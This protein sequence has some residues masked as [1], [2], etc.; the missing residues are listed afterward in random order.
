MSQQPFFERGMNGLVILINVLCKK[1]H[2]RTW[3]EDSNFLML[4]IFFFCEPCQLGKLRREP[5]NSR[6]RETR[7][8][9]S[10]FIHSNICGPMSVE[11]FG[12]RFFVTFID[13]ASNFRYVYFLKHKS[14]L[15]D[16]F[17]EFKRLLFNKFG[18]SM[19]T[20]HMDNKREYC[21]KEM[22]RYITSRGITLEYTAPYT[23]EQ[24]GKSKRENRTIVESAQTMLY[25]KKPLSLWAEAVN[26]T[27]CT[28]NRT[29]CVRTPGTTPFQIWTGKSRS[30]RTWEYLVLKHLCTCLTLSG[31]NWI[32]N[33]KRRYW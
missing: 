4:K 20:L 13:D 25:S 27:V 3:F 9:P 6:K 1:W 2:I 32:Q 19:K 33:K 17:K 18:Y 7:I 16:R 28:F 10:D 12:A 5:F 22:R 30:C 15:F 14:D 26:T 24:N 31:R 11:S 21:S 29:T 8:Q 23:P